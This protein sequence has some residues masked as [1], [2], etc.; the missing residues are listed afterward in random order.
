ML[1]NTSGA[2]PDE[3][4]FLRTR[5]EEERQDALEYLTQLF[6][7]V[8]GWHE[9][10]STTHSVHAAS[11]LGV[12]NELSGPFQASH[13]VGYLLLTAVDHLHALR[14]LMKEAHAQHV[15]APYSLIRA[16][17]EAAS[18][19]LWILAEDDPREIAVRALKLEYVNLR[20]VANAYRTVGAPMTDTKARMELLDGVISRN[21]MQ[22]DGIKASPPGSLKILEAACKAFDAGDTPV[23]MWQMCSGA[24]HGRNWVSGFLTMMEARNDPE[25]KIISGRLTSDEQA[26]LLA[27]FAACDLVRRLFAVQQQRSARQAHTGQSFQRPNQ[28]LLVPK[29]GLYLPW[30]AK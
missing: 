1:G 3:H 4:F 7:E 26:I 8:E 18:A 21:R 17:L 12:A 5:T 22:R 20:D 30:Q 11:S 15:F 13:S 28:N 23:L 2:E 10:V 16:A 24:A 14:T 25:A 27:M 6:S 29:R 19:A 9:R